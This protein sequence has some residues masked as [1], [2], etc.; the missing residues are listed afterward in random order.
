MVL[1][2]LERSPMWC[3]FPMS[4]KHLGSQDLRGFRLPVNPLD[5]QISQPVSPDG[6]QVGLEQKESLLTVWTLV[7]QLVDVDQAV[8]L[9]EH[10]VGSHNVC[11]TRL[12]WSS[13]E[14]LGRHHIR[15]LVHQLPKIVAGWEVLQ[16]RDGPFEEIKRVV[17]LLLCDAV[18]VPQEHHVHES[19][20]CAKTWFASLANWWTWPL[21]VP[22]PL[23]HV[24]DKN[25]QLPIREEGPHN[26]EATHRTTGRVGR[27]A[28]IGP[29]LRKGLHSKTPDR[30]ET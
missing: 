6:L 28:G 7:I 26:G 19:V 11:L 29:F 25:F 23:F 20:L 13:T 15:V 24:V 21:P 8:H 22:T 4:G 17:H 10:S 18:S 5:Q 27:E 3:V 2:R 16:L 30:S 9:V 12:T 14:E 1:E